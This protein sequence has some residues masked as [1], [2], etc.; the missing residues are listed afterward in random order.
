MVPGKLLIPALMS[1]LTWQLPSAQA[2]L[3]LPTLTEPFV[4]KT[5]ESQEKWSRHFALFSEGI[6]S[7]SV[8]EI[9]QNCNSLPLICLVEESWDK[10]RGHYICHEQALKL[11]K[12]HQGQD[13]GQQRPWPL[14]PLYNFRPVWASPCRPLLASM[15]HFEKLLTYSLFFGYDCRLGAQYWKR[16]FSK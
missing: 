6:D 12:G 13:Q 15:S 10:F 5:A 1:F 2:R 4:V 16:M 9:W 14:W 11:L 7:L 8:W 3:I